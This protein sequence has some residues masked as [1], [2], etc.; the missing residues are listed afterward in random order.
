[1]YSQKECRILKLHIFTYVC[2]YAC[3]CLPWHACGS[4]EDNL[5]ESVLSFHDLGLGDQTQVAPGLA[6][7]AFNPVNHLPDSHKHFLKYPAGLGTGLTSTVLAF[8]AWGPGSCLSTTKQT[9]KGKDPADRKQHISVLDIIMQCFA[10]TC[11][12]V[13]THTYI[14]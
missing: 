7:S 14:Y 3:M 8:H 5:Q 10:K 13:C 2:I 11:D 6:A 4:Q 1:M 12:C 9:E